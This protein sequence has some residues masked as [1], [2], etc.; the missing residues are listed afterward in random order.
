M[1]RS[2]AAFAVIIG[3]LIFAGQAF[4]HHSFAATYHEDKTQKIEGNVIQF[5]LRNPHSFLHVDAKDENGVMQKYAIEWG[6]GAQLNTQGVTKDS[7]KAGDHVIITGNPSRNPED[8]R[9][10]MQ[11]LTRPADGFKWGGRAGEVVN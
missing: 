5:L 4:S 2:L 11:T 6:G 9:L 1:K 10:R 7:L 3:G 8:H